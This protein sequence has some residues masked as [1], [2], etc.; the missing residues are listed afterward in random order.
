MTTRI[1][2][3]IFIKITEISMRELEIKLFSEGM[4]FAKEDFFLDAVSKMKE[5][6][7]KFPE[8]ELLDDALYNIGLC[9]FNLSQFETAISYF[10]KCI[11][12]Y[13]EGMIS[14]L[15]GADEYG[16]TAAKC[17]YAIMNCQLGLGNIKEAELALNY[18]ANYPDSY[19]QL[20]NNEKINFQKL[21]YN[22]F[23]IYC[24]QTK[25]N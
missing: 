18:L 24:D 8:S 15:N 3:P 21:A 20:P 5:L 6:I 16:R 10:Q 13:P 9:Y 23:R 4:N 12:E 17:Y 25:H 22:S 2:Q 1:K 19:I 7:I 11:E 14:V